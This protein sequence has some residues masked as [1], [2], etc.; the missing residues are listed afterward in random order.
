MNAVGT[1]ENAWLRQ[2]AGYWDMAAALAVQGAVN[3]ELFLVPSFSGEM[4]TVFAK[5]RPFL[6]ELREKIGNPELLA[7][8][9]TLINGSK[10]ERERL[11][12]F[13]VRLAARRKLMMEAAAAKAS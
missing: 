12:Q 2:V 4:F 7:N 13:E 6:K 1:P 9:E 11:K 3:Q 8:I 5:V 10:K